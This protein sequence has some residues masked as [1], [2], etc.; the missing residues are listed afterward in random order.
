[1]PYLKTKWFGTFLYDDEIIEKKLFPKNADEI[2]ERLYKILKEEV[3][4]EEKEFEKYEPIVDEKRLRK[5]GKLDKVK[6]LEVKAVDFGYDQDL[7]LNACIKVAMRKIEEEQKER[8]KR[9]SEAVDALDDLIKITNILL[10]RLRG[11]YS[12]FSFDEIEDGKELAEKLANIRIGEGALDKAEEKNLKNLA[13]LLSS[14]Y[15]VR[16]ELEAYIKKVM[17]EMAPN[18][19]KI[20]GPGIA[21]RLIAHAGGIE[22][23]ATLP[24]GTIQL[25]GAE[26]ALFRHIKDGSLPPK[27]GVIFQHEMINKAPK[28][29]RGKIARLLATKIAIAAKADAFTRN[30]IADDL[31]K[32]IEK[33]Y[34]EIMGK[35]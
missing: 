3:L 15:K 12:Y 18:V 10:E 11:W 8:T 22:K 16:Q 9:I 4:D 27:H 2:A 13:N 33:R 31:K 25:L 32:E 14:I 1:M 29:K 28:N 5:I 23:L 6:K 20:I 26:K 21:A 30:Y 35:A 24:A 17:E 7:L 34:R 19:S